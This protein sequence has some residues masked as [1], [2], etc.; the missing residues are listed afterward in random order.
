[1]NAYELADQLDNFMSEVAKTPL[2]TEHAAM[3]RKQADE[4]QHMQEQFDRAIEFLEKMNRGR[5]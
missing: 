2:F 4:L 1:M 5:K 3:L